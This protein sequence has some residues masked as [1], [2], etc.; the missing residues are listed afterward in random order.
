MVIIE[1]ATKI[2]GSP[3]LRSQQLNRMKN[4][5][6]TETLTIITRRRSK[7]TH[8][9]MVMVLLL[10]FNNMQST[11]A[12]RNDNVQNG[13]IIVGRRSNS[14]RASKSPFDARI[15]TPT[16]PNHRRIIWSTSEA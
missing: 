12:A 1:S 7:Q 2:M 8:Y 11:K 3:P 14:V 9:T 16:R 6:R 15:F 5:N 10:H 4:R 13:H